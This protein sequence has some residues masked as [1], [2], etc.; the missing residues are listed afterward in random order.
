MLNKCIANCKEICA[1]YLGCRGLKCTVL[2]I[3]SFS[4][5]SVMR[6]STAKLVRW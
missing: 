5:I 6:M 4:G 1:S 2:T 3:V